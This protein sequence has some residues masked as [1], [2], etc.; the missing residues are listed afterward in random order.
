M[1]IDHC[2]FLVDSSFPS[3]KPTVQEPDY[4]ADQQTWERVHC[5]KFLDVN[6]TPFLARM[7]W[8]PDWNVIPHQYRRQWGHYCLLRQRNRKRN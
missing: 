7:I 3:T 8:V 6:S 4:I 2:T 5:E 1:N